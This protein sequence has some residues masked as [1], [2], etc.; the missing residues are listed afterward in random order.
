MNADGQISGVGGDILRY[1]MFAYCM[2]NPVNMS[3]P[4]GNWPKWHEEIGM[5]FFN[6]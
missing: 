4:T 2:N 5:S 3:D 1:N 6:E